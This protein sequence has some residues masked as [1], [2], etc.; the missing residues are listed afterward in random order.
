MAES[1]VKLVIDSQ[2]FDAKLKRAGDALNRFFDVAKKGDRTFE[3]VDEGVMEAV[4]A[5]GRMETASK[6]AKGSLAELQ[7]AFTDMSLTYRRFTDEEKASPVG[8]AMAQSLSELKTRIQDTKKD[9]AA[10]NQ[11]LSGSKFGQFGGVIDTIG[12]KMGLT[13]NATELLTSKTAL[14]YAGIGAGIAIIGKASD[15]WAKYNSELA[16][17]DQ[18]TTVTTGLKG[19]EADKMTDTMRALSDTY[20]VDFREAVNAANTLMSQFGVNGEEAIRLIKDGMQ[21]M[22]QGDGPKLL[23]MIKQ[24]AP[25]FRDAGVSASQLVAVIH[26]SEGGIFTDQNMN[27]IVMGIKNIRLM[28]KQTSDALAQLGIDGKK[29][30]QDLNAGTITVFDALKQVAGELKNVDS[31]SQ[32]AG[33]VMQA[34]FGR[35]GVTAGTNIAKAIE[36]L[37]TN[38]E[39]TKKQTGE[40]GDAFA[41]LQTANEHLNTAIREAFSYDGWAEMATGIKSTLIDTLADVIDKLGTIK[42]LLAGIS[43]SQAK[44]NKYGTT[45]TPDEVK[46]D[47]E[48]LS[49]ADADN[50]EAMYNNMLRKYEKR[51]QEATHKLQGE[52]SKFDAGNRGNFIQ[53]YNPL[54]LVGQWWQST[55][56]NSARSNVAAEQDVMSQF[57][58]EA[59]KILNPQQ[60]PLPNNN[61]N[62]NNNNNGSGTKLTDQQKA[63][64]KFDQAEKDYNQALEQAA[65]EVKAGTADTVAAKKK[66]LQAAENLWK[67]IGDAREIYDSEELKTAQEDAAKKVVELGGSVNA[68]VEEQKKAQEAARKLAAAQEKSATAYQQMQTAQANNDLKAYNTALKQYQTAQADVTRLG[69]ELP[70]LEDKK[71][72]YTVEVNDDQLA[73]LKA[74]PTEDETIKIN[75]EEGDVNLPLVPKDDQTIRFNVEEGE[76]ELPEIPKEVEQVI[77]TK[78]GQVLTP[79]IADEVVQTVSTRLGDIVTPEIKEQ[80]TQTINTKVGEVITPEVAD[81]ITQTINTKVGDIEQPDIPNTYTVTIEAATQEA[82]ATVDSFVQDMDATKVEIPVSVEQP[83]PVEVPVTMSYTDNNMSAFLASLKE[84]IA[85]ED[86]GSTLYQNL[87]AQLADANAIANLMQTA[88]KNGIDVSQFNPKDLWKKVFGENPGDYIDNAQWQTIQD[89]INAKLKEMKLDPIKLDLKSGSVSTP[90]S[91]TGGN[92]SQDMKGTF[93]S[94]QQMVGYVASINNDLK[95]LGVEVPEG[96]SKVVSIINLIQ[97]TMAAAQAAQT[98]SS[99]TS[100]IPVVGGIIG[101]I[102]GIATSFNNGGI[103]HAANGFVVPGNSF[104]GDNV[105]A[106][107][108]SGE[109]ILNRAQQHNLASQLTYANGR[110]GSQESE[111]L[112]SSENI[113]IILKNGS[114]RR[115]MSVAEYLK[116]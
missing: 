1:R 96:F 21:G 60:T 87:T 43:P 12:H 48:A 77:N 39:E 41:D 57:R 75:V 29:M 78:V 33:Q 95:N 22:I 114:S 70:K 20:K 89:T 10:I 100:S 92:V 51:F 115:G 34:V 103:V 104:S 112:I 79:E 13:A 31:N 18:I 11:E 27:A 26:N 111:V 72:V 50:R 105:P 15:A 2:E 109:L 37:N 25:A 66:E 76:V 80:L 49:K 58:K 40:L 69:G 28:T 45:G 9:L 7:K 108:D 106:L 16:K 47:L 30:S 38:L 5:M 52:Q 61:N 116:L 62:N 19:T 44:Q 42:G 56:V 65:L 64:A 88:I 81:T 98:I 93:Q 102:A 107:L 23:Q 36:T 90:K 59:A 4:Q 14:M 67:S 74:L 91:S 97:T 82:A 17:Q 53:R 85:K 46:R 6:S 24:Y 68:L 94:V 110:N 73:K 86:V 54:G 101:L 113:R 3:V 32:A 8:K 63:Q 55:N 71:V 83:K 84:R 35:Q 99:A